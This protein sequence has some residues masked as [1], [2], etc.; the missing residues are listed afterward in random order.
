MEIFLI[1]FTA[2]CRKLQRKQIDKKCKEKKKNIY[3]VMH[4]INVVLIYFIIY[5][6]KYINLL[7]IYYYLP[8]KM[9]NWLLTI[10]VAQ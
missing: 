7:F 4:K 1:N 10:L 6:Y 5:R 9:Y 8:M 2:Y 3:K